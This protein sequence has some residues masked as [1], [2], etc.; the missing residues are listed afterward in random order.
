M[1]FR[2]SAVFV[3]L[4]YNPFNL[5]VSNFRT[6]FPFK[7]QPHGRNLIKI[8]RSWKKRELS[9]QSFL[10]V[11]DS[12]QRRKTKGDRR[13]VDIF[14]VLAE[15]GCTMHIQ[16]TAKKYCLVFYSCFML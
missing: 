3:S 4:A 7:K 15:V 8:V 9:R 1:L 10:A 2:K 14:T 12:T 11:V 5:H 6:R 16:W 13:E